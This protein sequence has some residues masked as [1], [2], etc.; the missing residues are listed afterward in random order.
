MRDML[1]ACAHPRLGQP[2]KRRRS[3]FSL[4][5]LLVAVILVDVGLLA[6]VQTSAIVVRRRNEARAR[7]AAVSTAAARV[8]QLLAS[9]CA[10]ATGTAIAPASSETWTSLVNGSIRDVSDSVSFGQ[11]APASH[12]FVLHSRTSC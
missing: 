7:E 9:P 12:A 1:F 8:E 4:V 11:P 6:L 2:G 3:G 5:E 10:T